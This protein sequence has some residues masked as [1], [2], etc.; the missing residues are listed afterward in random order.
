ML[1]TLMNNRNLL[2]RQSSRKTD[3]YQLKGKWVNAPDYR[4]GMINL[5]I[6][7]IQLKPMRELAIKLNINI[8]GESMLL[9]ENKSGRL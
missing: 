5:Y 2:K 6:W 9:P 1:P 7:T 8:E 4:Y 3:F